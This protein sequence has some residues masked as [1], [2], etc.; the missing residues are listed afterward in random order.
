MK[1]NFQSVNFNADAKLL[2]FIQA[3]LDKLDQFYDKILNGEVYLKVENA[4]NKENKLVEIKVH[5][6]GRE[7]MVKKQAHLFESAADQ[8]V[9]A[10]R[11]KVKKE[12]EKS[13]A[14]GV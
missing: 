3:K 12:K 2:A 13:R 4:S 10:L 11:R 14:V 8:A 7:L 6:P 9:E 5:L 1:V